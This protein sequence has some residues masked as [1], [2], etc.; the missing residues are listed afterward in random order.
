MDK[1]TKNQ[2]VF[3]FAGRQKGKAQQL[4]LARKEKDSVFKHVEVGAS[5][6]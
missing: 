2:Q 1:G 3:G 6:C 4:G 5:L